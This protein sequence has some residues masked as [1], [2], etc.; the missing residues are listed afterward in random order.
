MEKNFQK[1]SEV[2]S[3]VWEKIMIDRH[4]VN[5]RAD[6]VGSLYKPPLDPVWVAKYCQQS[7]YCLKVVKCQNLFCCSSFSDKLG[8]SHPWLFH[9]VFFLFTNTQIMATHQSNLTDIFKICSVQQTSHQPSIRKSYSWRKF[10]LRCCSIWSAL[11]FHE[12]LNSGVCK[13]C[14][15]H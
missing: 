13:T 10:P 3:E 5:C 4:S 6:P 7:R 2:L 8:H 11:L 14:G 12:K 9:T 15:K 1:A